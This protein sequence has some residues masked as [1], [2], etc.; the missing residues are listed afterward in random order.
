MTARVLL[1][2][3]A[4]LVLGACSS[5]PAACTA[6]ATTC[7]S[8]HAVLVCASDGTSMSSFTCASW[9]TCKDGACKAVDGIDV[10]CTP[11]AATCLTEKVSSVCVAAGVPPTIVGCPQGETCKDGLCSAAAICTPGAT[12]CVSSSLMRTCA[13]DGKSWVASDCPAGEACDATTNLCQRPT[14]VP[15]SSSEST[16]VNGV[17]FVC[18]KDGTGFDTTPCAANTHCVGAGRCQGNGPTGCIAGTTCNGDTVVTCSND[19]KTTTSLQCAVGHSCVVDPAT[20]VAS[21]KAIVCPAGERRCGN[22]TDPAADKSTVTS[23]CKA[24]GSGWTS[25]KCENGSTCFAGLCIFDCMAG[26]T[27]CSEDS[28]V[29]C[30]AQGKWDLAT[31]ANCHDGQRCLVTSP[32]SASCVDL[33]CY[34]SNNEGVCTDPDHYQACVGGILQPAIE[35]PGGCI[36]RSNDKSKDTTP[37]CL[38]GCS[39]GETRCLGNAVQTCEAGRWRTPATECND[40]SGQVTPKLC[41]SLS[42]VQ[43]A[44]KAVCGDPLC[45]T[46]HALCTPDGQVQY[47]NDGLLTAAT[48]CPAGTRCTDST[49]GCA[50]T[51]CTDGETSCW[52]SGSFYSVS[53]RTCEAGVWSPTYRT[54]DTSPLT[55]ATKL[56]QDGHDASGLQKIA[57]VDA[58]SCAPGATR[59]SVDLLGLETCKADGTWAAPTPCSFGTCDP[60][61]K[62]CVAQCIPDAMLCG[63]PPTTVRGQQGYTKAGK[64]TADGRLPDWNAAPA[65][66][67][68]TFCYKDPQNQVLGC[69]ECVGTTTATGFVDTRCS[70]DLGSI[71]FCGPSNKWDGQIPTQSCGDL[72]CWDQGY[73]YPAYCDIMY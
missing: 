27:T 22:P 29:A 40:S 10:A 59:C 56:C 68:G 42:D 52:D 21:C 45:A 61:A 5:P 31:V 17:P 4:A 32:S 62:V 2:L 37:E 47:C 24:D 60:K 19:G 43:G 41:L 6:K 7:A 33:L 48:P 55:G 23:T 15:C 11:G 30:G 57:C 8:D 18:K 64:C 69:V 13:A 20:R 9:E 53:Y 34:L 12:E 1:A 72:V 54:C 44:R 63:G 36:E 71:E 38:P 65:C 67:D 14:A 66:S 70:S 50:P 49:L 39:T 16:C 51:I 26:D 25:A 58:G 28:V 3:S 46:F 73:S 35:C